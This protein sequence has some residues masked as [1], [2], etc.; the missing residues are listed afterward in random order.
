MQY[1]LNIRF[2]YPEK[3]IHGNFQEMQSVVEWCGGKWNEVA[4][5]QFIEPKLRRR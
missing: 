4:V 2:I 5:K 3:M 1:A